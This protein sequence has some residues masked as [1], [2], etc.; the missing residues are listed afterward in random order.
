MRAAQKRDRRLEPMSPDR[1]H[2]GILSR[3][4]QADM[5]K[6]AVG[7]RQA[8]APG[9]HLLTSPYRQWLAS[10]SAFHARPYDHCRSAILP[11]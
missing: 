9:L 2:Y 1:R 10:R 8:K 6:T 5:Q 11:T 4:S 3:R 7:R